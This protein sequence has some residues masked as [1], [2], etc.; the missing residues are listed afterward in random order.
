MLSARC[1][2]PWI[3]TLYAPVPFLLKPVSVSFCGSK[4][5]LPRRTATFSRKALRPPVRLMKNAESWL[6][7]PQPPEARSHNGFAT[8]NAPTL[9]YSKLHCP[10]SG[11]ILSPWPNTITSPWPPSLQS[12][13]IETFCP[14]PTWFPMETFHTHT[15]LPRCFPQGP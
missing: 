6:V 9:G 3:N 11:F 1:C 4:V 14:P 7:L 2:V 12:P 13:S 5:R 10:R 8:C 15:L